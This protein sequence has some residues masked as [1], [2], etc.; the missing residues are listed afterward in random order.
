MTNLIIAFF[1]F[2]IVCWAYQAFIV[3]SIQA[4]LEA[5]IFSLKANIESIRGNLKEEDKEAFYILESSFNSLDKLKFDI[6]LV[7]LLLVNDKNGAET[8]AKGQLNIVMQASD[9]DIRDAFDEIA[10]CGLSSA[11]CNS[12]IL[13]IITSPLLMVWLL[14]AAISGTLKDK[15]N[16]VNL[17]VYEKSYDSNHTESH[18]LA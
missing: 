3:P 12:F 6:D 11:L 16:A 2:A 18:R 9:K 17:Y 15:K 5:K 1:V 7:E 13:L 14:V 10:Y 4:L 8:K